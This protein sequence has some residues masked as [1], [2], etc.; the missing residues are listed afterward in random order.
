MKRYTLHLYIYI[1]DV[2]Q[3]FA[4][5]VDIEVIPYME[6]YEV[7]EKIAKAIAPNAHYNYIEEKLS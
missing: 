4:I 3:R 1:N 5:D 2:T 6:L 7:G